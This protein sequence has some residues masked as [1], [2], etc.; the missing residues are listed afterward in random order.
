MDISN[1]NY[2]ETLV[3]FHVISNFSLTEKYKSTYFSNKTLQTLFELVRPYIMQYREEPSVEQVLMIAQRENMLTST[4]SQDVIQSLW[5]VRSQ[6]STY[7]KEWLD[8]CAKSYAEWNNFVG[9]VQKLSSYLLT[10]QAD[11]TVET[12]HEY[13]QKVKSMFTEDTSFTFHDSLGHDFFDPAEHK[14]IQAETKSTGYPFLDKCLNGG[15]Y[16]KSLFIIAGAPKVGK[17]QWLCNLCANSVKSGDN[18]A[19]ITLEM[20]V[21]K[22]NKRIGAN[23]F[24]IPYNEYDKFVADQDAFRRR[25]QSFYNDSFITPGALV[26]EQFPTSS[27]T[28]LELESFLLNIESATRLAS[29]RRCTRRFCVSSTRESSSLTNLDIE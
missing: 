10:T 20:G 19:Y 15:W 16:T 11:V 14:T 21:D 13:V 29:R 3:F 27:L 28:P 7:S 25:M 1:N 24:N 22:V 18:S 17:S 4:T 6:L 23:L 8:D 9:G 5:Q 26:V 2:T 12:C